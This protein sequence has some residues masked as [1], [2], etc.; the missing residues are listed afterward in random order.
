MI[1]W[2]ETLAG[3]LLAVVILAVMVFFAGCSTT[4]QGVCIVHG[5]GKT[6]SGLAA[7]QCEAQE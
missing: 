3:V 7:V 1:D 4:F 5:I 2:R 6:D